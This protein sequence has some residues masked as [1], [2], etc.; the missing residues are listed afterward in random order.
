MTKKKDKCSRC[1]YGRRYSGMGE[2]SGCQY[3]LLTGFPR[4]CEYGENCT[5]FKPLDK[6]KRTRREMKI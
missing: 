1:Y 4:E 3:I 5:K 2:Q 6:D